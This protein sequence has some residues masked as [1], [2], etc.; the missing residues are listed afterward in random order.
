M[1]IT[2]KPKHK[3]A[4]NK[5]KI[6]GPKPALT[7]RQVQTI[8]GVLA[9]RAPLRDQAL[10]SVA[11]DS[12]L[13][14][15][16]L[17]R[18]KVSDVMQ[19]GEM[20]NK[21]RVQPSKTKS[22]SQTSIVF[23]PS[24]DTQKLLWRHIESEDLI[25]TDFLFT[26]SH[27][28]SDPMKPISARAYPNL[29]KKWVGYAGLSSEVYGTHSIRRTRPAYFYRKTGNLRACQIMLGHKSLSSTQLYLG[30]EEEETL[31]LARE[32]EL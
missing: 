14:G 18:L 21:V 15:A 26:S 3:T 13:R 8:R 17:V 23:E 19:S 12:C 20:R 29:V 16:D 11:I 2:R 7:S 5:G 4:W 22:R 27:P 24:R 1:I 28:R 10:F 30:V 25:S 31:A 6:V 9:E 32:Y